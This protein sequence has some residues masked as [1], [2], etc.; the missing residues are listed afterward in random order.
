[1]RVI[2]TAGNSITN[3]GSYGNAESMGPDSPVVDPKSG[4][5][6]ARLPDDPKD[7]KSPFAEP[8]IAFS[9]IVGVGVTDKYIYAGDSITRRLLKLKMTYAAEETCDV[10]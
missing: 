5:L 2:D 4:K 7:L 9:W 8:E 3:I 1:V 10:K 6:R